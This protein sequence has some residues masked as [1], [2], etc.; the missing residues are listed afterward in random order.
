MTKL[1]LNLSLL[2]FLILVGATSHAQIVKSSLRLEDA[3]KEAIS[4]RHSLKAEAIEVLIK[5]AQIGPKAALEN[6]I[7]GFAFQNYPI[8]SFRRDEFG[9]TGNEISLSQ[10]F[11]FPGKLGEQS[12]AARFDLES[13]RAIFMNK[14]LELIKEVKTSYFEFFLANKKK[15]ILNEQLGLIRQLIGVKRSQYT[16]GKAQQTELLGLQVEEA[17][18]LDQMLTIEKDIDIKT[19]DLNHA[20][21]RTSHHDIEKP[22]DIKKTQIDIAQFSESDFAEKILTQNPNLMSMRAGV[23]S[24]DSKLS[25]SR[26]GYLPD[27]ELRGAYTSRVASPGARG[28]DFASVGIAFSLPIWA[29]TKQSEEIRGASAE[30]SRSEALLEEEQLHM[31][32]MI[33]TNF[34]DLKEASKRLKLYE[35]GLLPLVKQSVVSSRSSFVTGK[36]DYSTFLGLVKNRFQVELTYYELLVNFETRIAEFEALTGEPL[37][38]LK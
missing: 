6:P 11:S 26:M 32:H 3:I 25:F 29:V 18:L 37:G 2:S 10:R 20:I 14:K 7:L 30:R 23:R 24:A 34:A 21:G 12:R 38:G 8:D 17:G 9:M 31:L 1:S 22:E 33:H 4:N 15:I 16:L 27:F 13:Q 35:G 5:E 36:T 19:G 28:V